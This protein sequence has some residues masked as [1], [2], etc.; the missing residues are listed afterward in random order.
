MINATLER[1]DPDPIPEAETVLQSSLHTVSE[2]LNLLVSEAVSRDV[3]VEDLRLEA[4]RMYVDQ[5]EVDADRNV[6][7]II[8]AVLDAIRNEGYAIVEEN[9]SLLIYAHGVEVP[10]TE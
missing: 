1:P 3:D 2:Y 10:E 5:D 4:E 9:D 8:D 6:H 7:E